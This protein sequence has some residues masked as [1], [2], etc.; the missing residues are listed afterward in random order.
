ML[1]GD[2]DNDNCGG[3]TQLNED[4]S[5]VLFFPDLANDGSPLIDFLS[6]FCKPSTKIKIQQSRNGRYFKTVGQLAGAGIDYVN[7][8]EPFKDVVDDLS[9]GFR[10]YLTTLRKRE[11]AKERQRKELMS[12]K[13]KQN[14]I[15]IT[16]LQMVSKQNAVISN[17]AAARSINR[18]APRSINVDN[19]GFKYQNTNISN[20]SL[21][22]GFVPQ[23]NEKAK[24]ADHPPSFGA[25][26]RRH[27][28]R[29]TII[30]DIMNSRRQNPKEKEGYQSSNE[31][32]IIS[33][34]LQRGTTANRNI[35]SNNMDYNA[36][37]RNGANDK[38]RRAN[39]ERRHNETT[40]N[41]NVAANDTALNSFSAGGAVR[42]TALRNDGSGDRV[43]RLRNDGSG[44]RGGGTHKEP[45]NIDNIDCN[46]RA[47]DTA[48]LNDS[49]GGGLGDDSLRGGDL[50][51]DVGR[52]N[53]ND[54]LNGN[55]VKDRSVAYNNKKRRKRRKARGNKDIMSDRRRMSFCNDLSE[56]E[57]D[58]EVLQ[59]MNETKGG[60]DD[61]NVLQ[62]KE[63][64]CRRARDTD[65]IT[66]GDSVQ[67]IVSS[68]EMVK[69]K[70]REIGNHEGSN[71]LA[72]SKYPI[73]EVSPSSVVPPQHYGHYNY[74]HYP[75]PYPPSHYQMQPYVPSTY[76][77]STYAPS[78]YNGPSHYYG[79][80]SGNRIYERQRPMDPLKATV[81]VIGEIFDSMRR[82][83]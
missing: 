53:N 33:D 26:K 79:G 77:P 46:V 72:V 43:V 30:Q 45:R 14:M 12:L 31:V 18:A 81:Y 56:H 4:G 21:S 34:N 54:G 60:R 32:Q 50:D 42:G 59:S 52:H 51:N 23:Q 24:D 37:C 67:P 1:E 64:N 22:N 36:G 35:N 27:H 15:N 9:Q 69:Y 57:S 5:P 44:A 19:L 58:L 55:L 73:R 20:A 25:R 62:S 74:P 3:F 6:G 63:R 47:N 76:V 48:A 7:R 8:K 11:A 13:A 68:R 2:A 17:E 49:G 28:G 75:H 78:T 71:P 83:H 70:A 65:S 39:L 41:Y 61:L 38:P 40:D 66:T 82:N 29:N 80:T 16:N 10:Y